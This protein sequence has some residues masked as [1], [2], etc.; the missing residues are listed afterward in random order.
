[1]A[2]LLRG[3]PV[4]AAIREDLK[5]R[6]AALR[7]RGVTARLA[8][9][10]VGDNPDD[11]Y[12]ESSLRRGC[13]SIGAQTEHILLPGSSPRGAL[14]EA[15]HRVSE[16][17]TL[18]GCLLLRPLPEELSCFAVYD[19]L[20]AGK[21]L[22]GMTSISLG[23]LFSGRPGAFAPCTADAVMALLRHYGIDPAGKRAVVLG[24]SL[25]VGRPLA[26]LLMNADATVTVCHTQTRDLAA[27]CREA[28]LLITATGC[29]GLVGEKLLRPGQIVIDIGTTAI[30]GTLHGDVDPVAAEATAAAFT[31]VP[32]G[33]GAVTT[34][35][36]LRHLIEAAERSR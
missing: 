30:D 31:P 5:A 2:E 29:P 3:A 36:V 9:V 34:A 21:D 1:M 25:V 17:P 12:Y 22:D 7:A 13:E 28:E 8:L 26:Q 14:I 23:E 19:A 20:C 10:R 35:L 11:L 16:D 27:V 33:V 6:S 24:R 15:L 32:G 18:H 4:A